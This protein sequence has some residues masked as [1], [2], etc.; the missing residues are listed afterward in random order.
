MS[1]RNIPSFKTFSTFVAH[2]K[3]LRGA[4]FIAAITSVDEFVS[5]VMQSL[6]DNNLMDCVDIIFLS[7]HGIAD[8]DHTAYPTSVLKD[9]LGTAESD[10]IK[11]F[12]VSFV[13]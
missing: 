9:K 6:A 7:D 13:L 5:S 1:F 12:D 8:Y 4:E 10:K 2:N 11:I 3:G